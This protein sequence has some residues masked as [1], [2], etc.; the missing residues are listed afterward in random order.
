MRLPIEKALLLIILTILVLPSA[1]SAT[2][3]YPNSILETE[4]LM[5]QSLEGQDSH[6][7]WSA[8]E[9]GVAHKFLYTGQAVVSLNDQFG[10]QA[11]LDTQCE[12]CEPKTSQEGVPLCQLSADLTCSIASGGTAGNIGHHYEVTTEGI[13][14]D[15]TLAPWHPSPPPYI[16]VLLKSLRDNIA[17]LEQY[18][19]KKRVFSDQ[20]PPLA[21][22][23]KHGD[24]AGF[25]IPFLTMAMFNEKRFDLVD[26]CREQMLDEFLNNAR[27]GDA[28]KQDSELGHC[29]SE[30]QNITDWSESPCRAEVAW[31][32]YLKAWQ[33]SLK[34]R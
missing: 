18:Y 12:K 1:A 19:S 3:P 22:R 34:Q 17:Y 7:A 4:P 10:L 16:S 32:Y 2:M 23:C 13:K 31:P 26:I 29:L 15:G 21:L 9:N 20:N 25:V 24:D 33:D 30:T 6:G 28:V 8:T 27:V 11:E 5:L 14:I